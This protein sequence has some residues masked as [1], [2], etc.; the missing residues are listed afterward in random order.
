MSGENQYINPI[1][2]AMAHLQ[3]SRMQQAQFA[4]KA[5]ENAAQ[6]KQHQD[7]LKI[8][9]QRA[10][11]AEEDIKNRHEHEM[12]SLKNATDL[13]TA[14]LA[15]HHL[16]ELNMVRGIQGAG[17]DLSKLLPPGS[18][19]GTVKLPS[20]QEIDPTG[21]P[22]MQQIQQAEAEAAAQKAGAVT[23]AQRGAA[24][25]FDIAADTRKHLEDKEKR[26]DDFNKA[27]SV[28]ASNGKNQLDVANIHAAAQKADAQINGYNHLRGIQLM[29][30][31]GMDDGSG[32]QSTF[33][34]DKLNDIY[35]G[36][37]D[38]S[39][40]PKDIQRGVD[41]Y[42]QSTGETG[43][44]TNG[45]DH[46]SSLDNIVRLQALFDQARD[47]ATNYSKDSA[48]G[49]NSFMQRLQEGQLGGLVPVS[50]LNSKVATFKTSGGELASTF[51]KQNRKTDA[52][53]IR[54]VQGMFDPKAT[55][56]EN[57]HKIE[58]QKNKVQPI[59]SR[60]LGNMKPD[61]QNLVLK[62]NGITEWGAMGPQQYPDIVRD[63][64]KGL[65]KYNG[66]GDRGDPKNY[67]PY[68]PPTP[69]TQMGQP[70]QVPQ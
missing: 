18:K 66:V 24:E 31:L 46:A 67:A 56:Q 55:M 63:P 58:D 61:R 11:Q 60:A 17:G 23:S 62:D 68:V 1:I 43:M 27:M 51:D 29:H 30:Q 52:E 59:V 33:F 48:S 3:Q 34:K 6:Q 44:P 21:L 42:A 5:Q 26:E 54:Q 47:L 10:D 35:D 12:G 16:E 65:M 28:S 38:Y 36:K 2:Q 39:K 45:K 15:Q 37:A 40:L 19:P 50:E 49:K 8:E 22:T 9:Q 57:F 14:A 13:A 41:T 69:G 4:Q 25:P 20:G 7:L 32:V 53:I 64:Q 70:Q